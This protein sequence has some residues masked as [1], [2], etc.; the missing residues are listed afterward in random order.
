MRIALISGSVEWRRA[1]SWA[2]QCLVPY[3]GLGHPESD[4]KNGSCPG[5][6]MK[7]EVNNPGLSLLDSVVN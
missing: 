3:T 6:G 5:I 1:I 2:G 7:I 4:R